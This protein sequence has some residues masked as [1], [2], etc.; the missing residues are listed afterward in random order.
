MRVMPPTR[1]TSST[2]EA[3]SPAS[4]RA[5]RQGSTSLASSSAQRLSSLA[6][7]SLMF[8]CFGP[9]WSAV[10]KGRLMSVSMEV[11]SSH[12]AFSAASLRRCRAILSAAQVDA[13]LLLELVGHVV[14]DPLVEVL[15]AQEGVA[16]GRLDLEDPVAELE[17]GD[18]EGAAAE[19]ED[20]D[21]LVL[22]LVQAVGQ[23]R[24]GRLV[25][26]AQHV[27]AGDL[28]GVLGRL[29]LGVVEVGRNGDDRVGDLLAQVVLGGLLH[30]LQ[31]H[32][33]DLRRAVLFAPDLD[34][35]VA[36]VGLDDLE[37]ADL[38]VLLDRFGIELAADQ[39][40]DGEEGVFRVG[41]RLALGLLAD[42]PLAAFGEGDHR[43][44]GAGAFRVGDDDRLAAFHDGDAGVGRPQVDADDFSHDLYP[45]FRM[46]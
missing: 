42:Q 44:G 37:R 34:P 20:G 31:H 46:F 16:V 8:R 19:V 43:R 40:L 5:V 17:D 3:E 6:R 13:L 12:L 7:V 29:A 25:D 33:R 26:D 35:G 14:D 15:A 22:L 18:V 32:G 23:R 36:V 2:S 38:D 45:P 28:A 41:D 30:L 27:E 24:G 10:M 9:F 1:I 21:L 39:A 4:L 11:E